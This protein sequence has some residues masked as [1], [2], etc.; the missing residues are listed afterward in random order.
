M[1]EL[2]CSSIKRGCEEFEEESLIVGFLFARHAS[3]E[4]RH[5]FPTYTH[6]FSSIFSS[7]AN[8]PANNK[9]IFLFLVSCIYLYKFYFIYF[10]LYIK[11]DF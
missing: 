4:G 7:E 2:I 1:K 10:I 6:W 5:I 9:K 8:S 11:V 3:Q